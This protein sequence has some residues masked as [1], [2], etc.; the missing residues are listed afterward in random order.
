MGLK[1]LL[2]LLQPLKFIEKINKLQHSSNDIVQQDH[3][4][5]IYDFML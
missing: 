4:L 2:L 3:L 1:K 5:D